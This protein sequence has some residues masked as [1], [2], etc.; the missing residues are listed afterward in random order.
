MKQVVREDTYLTE[1]RN[2][3]Y[4]SFPYPERLDAPFVFDGGFEG[5]EPRT[6]NVTQ[7]PISSIIDINLSW[8]C[9]MVH[10]RRVDN[11]QT[12]RA[13]D[14]LMTAKE[15]IIYST[16][17][18]E[19]VSRSWSGTMRSETL[20]RTLAGMTVASVNSEEVE[21]IFASQKRWSAHTSRT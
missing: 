14:E 18:L 7:P 19:M 16:S 13:F 21:L 6:F 20:A 10:K 5:L 4:P 1:K 11:F 17:D 2:G 12:L 9:E 3:I 8:T 15:D